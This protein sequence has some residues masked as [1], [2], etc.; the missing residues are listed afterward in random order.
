MQK[1]LVNP[2]KKTPKPKAITIH[3][4]SKVAGYNINRQKLAVFLYRD[5]EQLQKEIKKT[6]PKE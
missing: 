1:I 2:Q 5:N 6:I 4:F 3:E